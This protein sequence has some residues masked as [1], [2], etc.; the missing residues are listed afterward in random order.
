MEEPPLGK[1]V[2]RIPVDLKGLQARI[3]ALEQRV[4]RQ[5]GRI[6]RRARMADLERLQLRVQRIEQTLNS[7]LWA[8]H[9]REYTLLEMLSKPPLKKVAS[10]RIKQLWRS[11]IPAVSRWLHQSIKCCWLELRHVWW[12]TLVAAWQESLDKAR[13]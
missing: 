11:E 10:E 4:H 9:Q 8:A 7:E 13:R 1:P 5:T 6:T 12:P 3:S 2:Q